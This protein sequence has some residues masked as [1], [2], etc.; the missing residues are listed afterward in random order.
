MVT[1][2]QVCLATSANRGTVRQR[3]AAEAM[4]YLRQLA[5]RDAVTSEAVD[6]VRTYVERNATRPPVK[7]APPRGGTFVM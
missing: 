4:A 7:F 6:Y 2:A 5:V 1:V 3:Y